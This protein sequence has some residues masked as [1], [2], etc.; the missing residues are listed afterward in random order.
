[1]K[2]V[3]ALGMYNEIS[4]IPKALVGWSIFSESDPI[5]LTRVSEKQLITDEVT[6]VS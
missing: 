3:Y 4:M 1:M 2:M 6:K 5:G